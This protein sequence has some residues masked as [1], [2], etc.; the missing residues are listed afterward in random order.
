VDVTQ[1]GFSTKILYAFLVSPHR[2]LLYFTTCTNHRILRCA[3]PLIVHLHHLS[4]PKP[5]QNFLFPY[6]CNLHYFSKIRDHVSHPHI[7]LTDKT[8]FSYPGLQ[9]FGKHNVVITVFTVNNKH[10]QN[11]FS[12]FHHQLSFSLC[13][14]KIF[15]F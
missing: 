11:P 7:K 10:F 6:I 13:C 5:F 15:K 14:S 1:E 9:L 12:D 8:V 3:M 2:S 4:K